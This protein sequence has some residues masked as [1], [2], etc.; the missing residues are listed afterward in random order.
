MKNT[1]IPFLFDK[2]VLQAAIQHSPTIHFRDNADCMPINKSIIH[3]ITILLYHKMILLYDKMTLLYDKTILLYDNMILFYYK[4]IL[5]YDKMS[6][7]Y[8]KMILFYNKMILLYNKM[9]LLYH[10]ITLFH[11]NIVLLLSKFL[12]CEIIPTVICQKIHSLSKE[13]F[14]TLQPNSFYPA[15][16]FFYECQ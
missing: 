12:L 1:F 16:G 3:K 5:L 8:N 13:Y 11:P 14:P 15:Q 6:L 2:V 10:K 4:M 9:I 7:L